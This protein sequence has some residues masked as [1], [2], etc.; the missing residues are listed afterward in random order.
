MAGYANRV[1]T[2]HFPELSEDGE[3]IHVV[4][5]NP[6]LVPPG[7]MRRRDVATNDDGTPADMDE[8]MDASYELIAKL[9][10]G[11]FAY[12]AT[13]TTEDQPRL[14]P[15]WN[16]ASVAKLPL[17]IINGISEEIGNV[18][19]QKPTADQEAPTSRT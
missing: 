19:P 1:R 3:D 11:M 6:K 15:P 8:A 9:I 13:A 17:E 4:I 16:A 2:L 5:R 14:M 10:I 18:N 12:D 7:E